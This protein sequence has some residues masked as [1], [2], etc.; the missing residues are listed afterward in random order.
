MQAIRPPVGPRNPNG[1]TEQLILDVLR[2]HK[3]PRS[4]TFR[5]ERLGSDNSYLGDLSNVLAGS[6]EQNW[7]A[8]I[9]RIAKFVLRDD[10]TV[11]FLQNR[12]RPIV[13]LALPPFRNNDFVEWPQGVFLLST[14]KRKSSPTNVVTRDV[15]G[16]DATKVY[17]DDK[18]IT[19]YTAA[20]GTVC[21]TA[22]STL[23]GSIPKNVV[24][25]TLTLPVAKEW[26][27]GTTKLKII[28]D[29]IADINYQSL[30]FD[31]DG[32]AIVRPY[33]SPDSRPEEYTYADDKDGVVIP[34][35]EQ[36]LDLFD[37]ANSWVLVVS[38]PDRA[39]PLIAT[40]TNNDPASPTSTVSRQR[41]I[42]DYREEQEAASQA[43]L[44][45]KVARMAFEASQIY[46]AV[47]FQT[48]FM[49]IHSGNDVYRIVYDTLA[50]NAKYV[51]HTWSLELKAGTEMKHRARRVVDVG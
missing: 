39:S 1:H 18:V 36:E 15:E 25:S 6:V 21:T 24:A 48:A 47:D 20:A 27:P 9:K 33:I 12:I 23:L 19:R 38:D 49:P 35:P 22:I 37:I 28:G 10:G 31:E 40:Y 14:P 45:A 16:Y 26:P 50:I 29:L 2:G 5:Y 7:L 30:S 43:V 41:T 51:E 34:D 17:I 3:G 11:N 4:F 8:D 44:D 46:E 13:R 32:V 42:T